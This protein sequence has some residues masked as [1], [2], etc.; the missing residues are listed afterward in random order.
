M[1]WLKVDDSFYDHPKV[2]DAPDCAVA[3]WTRAGCWAARNLTDGF[4]PSSM[5]ARLCDDPDT[6]VRE[7]IRRGLWK[8]AKGGY[9]FHDWHEYQPTRASVDEQRAAARERMRKLRSQRKTAGQTANGSREH[10]ANF[11]RSSQPPTRPDP[12]TL[13]G[14]SGSG[15]DAPLAA[16]VVPDPA[17]AHAYTPAPYGECATCGLPAGNRR[18]LRVVEGGAA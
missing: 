17:A 6:A 1:P 14:C 18:H 13:T 8:R 2:F 16:R 12:N 4:V 15:D 5:P 10:R 7:L 9:Q 11:G 3:L